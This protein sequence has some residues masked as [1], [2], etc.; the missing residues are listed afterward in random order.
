MARSYAVNAFVPRV[1]T[2]APNDTR[3][4]TH[5]SQFSCG[6]N[7]KVYIVEQRLLFSEKFDF[8]KR[9]KAYLKRSR[10]AWY[11]FLIRSTFQ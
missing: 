3:A 1:F 11:K 7:K 2:F 5:S 4:F 6:D 10:M 8:G 9:V